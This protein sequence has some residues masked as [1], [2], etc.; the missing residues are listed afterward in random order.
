MLDLAALGEMIRAA[1]L[2]REWR[3]IDFALAMRWS[4]TAPVYRLEGPGP[5]TPR[6]TPDTINLLAQVLELDYADRMTLL[7]FAGH[8]LDT[9]PLSAREEAQLVAWTRP[10][11]DASDMPM[12]LYDYRDRILAVNRAVLRSFD[13]DPGSVEAWHAAGLTA[14]DLLWDAHHGFRPHFVN[15]EDAARSQMLRFKL[16]NRLRRHEVW[17]RA[18]PACSAHHPGFMECWEATDRILERPVAEWDL[19]GVMQRSNDVVGPGGQILRFDA[20]RREVPAGYGLAALGVYLPRDD[21]TKRW[22]MDLARNEAEP[23]GHAGPA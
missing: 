23:L 16:D 19:S 9:E 4:G 12:I 21:S 20:S 11:M 22:M 6:P 2:R 3:P 14:F 5:D 18:Y 7:G 8:L 17:Y 15:I 1:R 10:M 13:L